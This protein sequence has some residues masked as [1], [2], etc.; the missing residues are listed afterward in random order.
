M[1]V[2]CSG[3][4]EL[5]E[6]EQALQRLGLGLLSE[7]IE[8]LANSI[9]DNGD[10]IIQYNEL[11]TAVAKILRQNSRRRLDGATKAASTGSRVVKSKRDENQRL[12]DMLVMK[13]VDMVRSQKKKSVVHFS[14]GI[15]RAF[16]AADIK[17]EGALSGNVFV[18]VVRNF[19]GLTV[20]RESEIAKIALGLQEKSSGL[21]LYHEF[22][23][24]VSRRLRKTILREKMSD[25][26]SVA[27]TLIFTKDELT[28]FDNISKQILTILQRGN[29]AGSDEAGDNE[30]GSNE[31]GSNEA[32]SN[33]A[34]NNEAGLLLLPLDL[35]TKVEEFLDPNVEDPSMQAEQFFY[36]LSAVGITLSSTA[37]LM[38]YSVL[39][40]DER[41][42]NN[43]GGGLLDQRVNDARIAKMHA[44]NEAKIISKFK[45]LH[46]QHL[47]QE[48]AVRVD[49]VKVR[50]VEKFR[51][52]ALNSI[53][54][55]LEDGGAIELRF[56]AA[57]DK[58]RAVLHGQEIMQIFELFDTDGDGEVSRAEFTQAV[59]LLGCDLTDDD[60]GV[61]FDMLD[62]SGDDGIDLNEFRYAWFNKG[63]MTRMIQNNDDGEEDE[64]SVLFEKKLRKQAT[65]EMES[66]EQTY[67]D[68]ASLILE[69]VPR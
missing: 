6:F 38:L 34:G 10:G 9:D 58:I 31:A 59:D 15:R 24:A 48:F 44:I 68:K 46:K 54:D 56:A 62:P 67:Q 39:R 8:A 66:L 52:R 47:K 61:C 18:R 20:G 1:D 36:L 12:S 23:D 19:G 13:F 64:S 3:T 65:R 45:V 17:K 51:L 14:E 16:A 28:F 25:S 30:A 37:L 7:E 41:S 49:N 33:E 5:P 55:R 27:R 50:R 22:L 43:P 57:L 69:S 4:I 35:I 29:E 63:K 42:K 11:V 21:I 40:L 2:D 60:V 26:N 53:L 32:G